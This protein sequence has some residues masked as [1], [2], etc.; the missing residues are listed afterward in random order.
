MAHVARIPSPALSSTDDNDDDDTPLPFPAALPR[1]DFLASEFH[2]AAYLSALPHRHQT[3][4]DLRADL[5]DRSSAI[6]AELL[7]L[8]NANYTAFLSLGSELEGG[9]DRVEGLRV[10]LLG[11]RRAV[12]EIKANVSRR[13][14]ETSALNAKLRRVRLSVS[15]ARAMLDLSDRLSALE[16]RLAIRP[17]GQAQTDESVTV[18]AAAADDDDHDDAE[19][20][21]DSDADE[22]S[23][24]LLGSP[25]AKLLQSARECRRLQA[26]AAALDAQHPFVAKMQRRLSRCR[27]TLL[28]DLSNALK[29]ARGAGHGGHDRVMRYLEIYRVLESPRE[30]V[31]ALRSH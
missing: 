3:L 21:E 1:S 22:H 14:C 17:E 19:D 10:A 4:E 23:H 30:A 2:P 13:R 16:E 9:D 7:E 24:G 27:S 20:T 5:R 31:K 25:P 11:F 29:E 18:D 28:L 15:R 8:V 12:D 26:L 6:S